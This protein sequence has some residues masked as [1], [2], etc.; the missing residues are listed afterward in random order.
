MPVPTHRADCQTMIW[1]TTCPDC[2]KQVWYFSC[3]CGSRV[4]FD[5]KGYP[6]PLHQDSCP[7]YNIRLMI[8]DGIPV[9]QIRLLLVS[10]ARARVAQIPNDI[11][12][13]LDANDTSSKILV[14]NKLPSE[15]PC[16]AVGIVREINKINFFKRFGLDPNPIIRKIL[17]KLV[18]EPYTEIIIREKQVGN[19]RIVQQW[20]FVIPSREI[21]AYNLRVGMTI[22]AS[23]GAQS[24]L[25]E[26][27]V[28]VAVSIDWK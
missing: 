27:A 15:E 7:I 25:D 18:T 5:N 20:S 17:G 9:A 8:Q 4:F 23:L 10:E 24:I 28:W 22:D 19:Q 14:E 13:Y 2:K 21:E 1:K 12:D 11:R 3:T 6:W 16:Q 26:D